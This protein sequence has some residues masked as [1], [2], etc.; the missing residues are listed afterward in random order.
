VYIQYITPAAG[1]TN[2]NI[3]DR[4]T[5]RAFSGSENEN[6]KLE[7]ES[8]ETRTQ[9][10]AIANAQAKTASS[11]QSC[12]PLARW[13]QAPESKDLE[14]RY[15][16]PTATSRQTTTCQAAPCAQGTND[17]RD[18]NHPLPLC[19][20]WSLMLQGSLWVDRGSPGTLFCPN[21]HA[22]NEPRPT[23]RSYAANAGS[24]GND[25]H[26]QNGV[27]SHLERRAATQRTQ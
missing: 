8:H 15:C 18:R 25:R 17:N 24:S 14:Y 5:S 21:S 27:A 10:R 2:I 1:N 4:R 7:R 12:N 13:S 6:T 19:G 11:T 16:V 9:R 23:C 26:T 3:I 20:W 22:R